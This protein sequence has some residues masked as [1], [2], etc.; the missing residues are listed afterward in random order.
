MIDY[1][2]AIESLLREAGSRN[3]D[4]EVLPLDQA[5]GRICAEDLTSPLSNQPFDNA[6][7][8]GFALNISCLYAATEEAPAV[9]EVIGRVAAGDPAPEALP[10]AGQCYEI[11]TGAPLPPGC[12]A[13]VPVELAGREENKISFYATPALNENIRRA[14]E[15]V[16]AGETVMQSGA[17]FGQQHILAVATLG[18]GQVKV[19]RKPRVGIVSTGLEVVDNLSAKLLPGQIYNS[20]GPYLRNALPAFGADAVSYGTVADDPKAFRFKLSEMIRDKVDVIVTT[21]AV[22][23]GAYDFIR[24]EL[25]KAGAEILF[26]KVK[27]RPGK[28]ILF[29]KLPDGGPFFIGLP[30][31]PVASTAGLR[32]FVYPLLRALSGLAPEQPQYAVLANDYKKKPGF[33]FFFRGVTSSNKSGNLQVDILQKQQSFMVSAFLTANA[34]IIA[35]EAAEEMKAGEVVEVYSLH[36]AP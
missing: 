28:P 24:T 14:G 8:D 27:I 12:N 32:F 23:A 34:W 36:P 11:M 33:R 17:V 9:L 6:A 3:L 7:M 5:P 21:G 1:N 19:R 25:E 30:G 22:S 31:N 13:V 20:T 26:H 15:D 35:P 4:T 16:M 29:A 18:I 10:A 2:E